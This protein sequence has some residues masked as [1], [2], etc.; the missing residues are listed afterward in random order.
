MTPSY[1]DLYFTILCL[2]SRESS[3][4]AGATGDTGLTPGSGRFPWRREWQPTSVFLP[5][6]SYGQ[7]SLVGYRPWG[8]KELDMTEALILF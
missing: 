2:S 8:H 4:N 1:C 3:Y 7:R 5:E 6:V